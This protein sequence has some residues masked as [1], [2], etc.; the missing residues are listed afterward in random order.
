M[1]TP[2]LAD[3]SGRNWL[4]FS[5]T[6]A[7]AERLF[8]AQYYLFKNKENGDLRIACDEYGLPQHVREHVDFIMPTIQLDG[9]RP[10]GQF[11]LFKSSP[12]SYLDMTDLS[13]CK[14][15]MTINCLRALYGIPT[16]KHNH[17]GNQLGIP[18][19]W[20]K[21]SA[22]DLK[23]FHQRFT[24]PKIPADVF[25]EVISIGGEDANDTATPTSGGSESALDVQTAYSIIWPQQVRLYSVGESASMEMT[26]SFNVFLDA[27]VGPASSPRW[28]LTNE[29]TRPR[30]PHTARIKVA[31][32]PTRIH[33]TLAPRMA[34]TW[35]RYNAVGHPRATCSPSRTAWWK[36]G[37]P[38]STKSVS[39][40]NG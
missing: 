12:P 1:Q 33:R 34:A 17:T 32:S 4:E 21:L 8:D 5:A 20:D 29:L 19:W 23:Q 3:H 31:I 27:L 30:T 28:A 16:G 7:E 10:V 35:A 38:A 2:F 26:G 18:Q 24:D 9:L 25:P 37:F 6:I 15:I 14:S 11:G 39:V 36:A 40:T 13:H 22:A